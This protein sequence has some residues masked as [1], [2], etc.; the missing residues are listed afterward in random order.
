M[1]SA[2]A[3]SA[4]SSRVSARTAASA[5]SAA[6][7]AAAA[8]EAKVAAGRGCRRMPRE[9]RREKRPEKICPK[10]R[11]ENASETSV[12]FAREAFRSVLVISC[13]LRASGAF[14]SVFLRFSTAHENGGEA[15][16][17]HPSTRNAVFQVR[18]CTGGATTLPYM[19]SKNVVFQPSKNIQNVFF[20]TFSP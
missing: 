8:L 5:A 3:H 13:K 7:R 4:S 20:V 19:S 6:L 10:K 12:F 9:T 14:R 11:E 17:A 1:P 18:L 15:K 16:N 2:G